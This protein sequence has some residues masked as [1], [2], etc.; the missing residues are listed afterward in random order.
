MRARSLPDQTPVLIGYRFNQS[1]RF[2]PGARICSPGGDRNR[3]LKLAER[4]KINLIKPEEKNQPE[5]GSTHPTISTTWTSRQFLLFLKMETAEM[6]KSLA[7]LSQKESQT[8]RVVT[9]YSKGKDFCM[10]NTCRTCPLRQVCVTDCL[11]L[12]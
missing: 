7:F 10:Q 8:Q 9:I 2:L 5:C 3:D 4:K 12:N 11:L 1:Q 6:S